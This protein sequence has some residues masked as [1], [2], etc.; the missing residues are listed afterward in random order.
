MGFIFFL[1]QIIKYIRI[2]SRIKEGILHNRVFML[3]ASILG[4][5]S[6]IIFPKR[7]LFLSVNLLSTAVNCVRTYCHRLYSI[8]INSIFLFNCQSKMIFDHGQDK[9]DHQKRS[10]KH[11]RQEIHDGKVA[12]A[13]LRHL[14]DRIPFLNSRTL[15]SHQHRIQKIVII[16]HS[17]IWVIQRGYAFIA[18][19]TNPADLLGQIASVDF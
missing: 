7:S 19:G 2:T 15:K 10:C 4:D 11:Q 14:H 3:Q 13:L 5:K 8:G 12:L 18:K 1:L 17:I 9:I 16:S 6:S